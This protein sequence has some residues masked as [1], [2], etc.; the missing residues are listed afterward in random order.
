MRVHIS[1]CLKKYAL[2]AS[3]LILL[4]T[5]VSQKSVAQE[6]QPQVTKFTSGLQTP[7]LPQEAPLD[8]RSFL[9][10]LGA[11]I[12]DTEMDCSHF[13]QYLYEQAGLYYDYA[14]SRVLYGGM[15]PF[16]RVRYP[17]AGDVIVWRG[18]V[19]V[20]VDPEEGT[21]LSAVDSGVKT[22]SYKSGYWKR[23]GQ[24]HFL[25]YRG[26]DGESAQ[27]VTTQKAGSSRTAR[28]T[29]TAE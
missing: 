4:T 13:V 21:F 1:Q 20:V 16:K 17:E 7:D 25:R 23:R 15:E 9:V 3:C 12:P 5:G 18:H 26:A 22:Q 29:A 6:M 8:A 28:S 2:F 27:A 14:P 19:G 10:Q 11:Q 24:P